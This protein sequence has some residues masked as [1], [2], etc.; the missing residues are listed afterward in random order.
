MHACEGYQ[1]LMARE[2]G[3]LVLRRRFHT[4]SA[5]GRHAR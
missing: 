5:D 3:I 2:F 4:A 1:A